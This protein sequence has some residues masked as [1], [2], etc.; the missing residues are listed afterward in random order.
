MFGNAVFDFDDE[1]TFDSATQALF[2]THFRSLFF[3]RA[4][5]YSTLVCRRRHAPMRF[6]RPILFARACRT[7]P[8]AKV[9]RGP[10]TN[11]KYV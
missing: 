3:A 9:P 6:G 7:L 10:S 8:T 1:K 4:E 2:A 11:T 5:S